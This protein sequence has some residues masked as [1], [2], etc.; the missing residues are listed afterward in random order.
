MSMERLGGR[1]IKVKWG[2]ATVRLEVHAEPLTL[3]AVESAIRAQWPQ[4]RV[5]GRGG[6]GAARGH[7]NALDDKRR[8]VHGPTRDS[9][10]CIQI[11]RAM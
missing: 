1:I 7:Q 3:V 10:W 11:A 9:I 8:S 4:V 5:R 2:D 6:G